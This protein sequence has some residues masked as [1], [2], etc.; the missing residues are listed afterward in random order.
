MLTSR[1][2]R[3]AGA[4]GLVFAIASIAALPLPA[5]A[6]AATVTVFASGLNN[7]RGLKFGPDGWLYVAEG[8]VGGVYSTI[9]QC[10]QVPT[11]GPYTG[12]PTGSRISRVNAHGY[13]ET[14]AEGFPS[15]QTIASQG[16]LV[17]GVADIAFVDG[18]LYGVLAGAGC[19]HGVPSLPNGVVRVGGHGDWELIANLSKFQMEHPT[20][21]IEE[22]DFEPDGT[23]YSMVAVDDA[24]FAVEPN[25]GELDRISTEGRIRRIADISASQGHIVP[26]AIAWHDGAFYV[27]NLNRF[28]I[29]QGGSKI[30]RI[31]RQGHIDTIATGLTTVLGLAFDQRGR[32]YA[33]ENTVG[34]AFPAPNA[35]RVVRV[36]RSG[37]LE[38]IAS[39]LML[40]TAMTFGHDGKLYVSAGGF[41]LPPQGLGQILKIEFTPARDRDDD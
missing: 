5:S 28:P 31:T 39:G 4:A 3:R 27:G 29:V 12:S 26:T 37:E 10:T 8:G 16:S 23:W 24:L 18:T 40:P 17:S 30:L 35:G 34:S 32:L 36:H 13:V 19:S 15:S 22:D 9:G 20:Q 2:A 11:V 25:H 41:G 6:D 33:L 14:V 38:V 1:H 21:V 7:P